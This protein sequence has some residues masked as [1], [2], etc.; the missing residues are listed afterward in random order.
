MHEWFVINWPFIEW[1]P[2]SLVLILGGLLVSFLRGVVQKLML[3]AAPTL[4]LVA[5]L[6]SAPGAYAS[7]EFLNMQMTLGR[8]DP[9]S[10]VFAHV[11]AIMALVGAIYALHVR[12]TIQHVAALIYAGSAMGVVFAGDLV[13]LYVFWELMMLSSVWL[14][15]RNRRAASLAAGFR[16]LLVHAVSGVLLLAGIVIYYTQTG[17]LSFDAIETGS[18]AFWLILLGFMINAAVPPLH[19]WL[20]DAYPEATVTGAVFLCAFTTKTAVYTL[21]RGFPEAEV[22]V[23]LGTLMTLWGVTYAVLANN[24]RR[25]LAY[26]I[27]SQ[28]GFMVAGIGLGTAM[29]LNGSAAHAFT[30]ILYKALLF[31]SAGAIIQMTGRAKLT[32]LGGLYRHMPLTFVFYMIAA[33]S[34]SALPLTS[35][36]V[37]KTM[38]LEAYADHQAA[39]VWLVL[40]LASAGTFL[41]VGLKLPWFVFMGRDSGLRPREAP[42]N[43]LVAMGIVAFF[44]IFIGVYPQWLYQMLPHQPVGYNAYTLAH[45]FWDL[46][47][48]SFVGLV[49]FV[50][51]KFMAPKDKI[52]LDTD[53]FYRVAAPH[54]VGLIHR[55]GTSAWRNLLAAMR[56]PLGRIFA[57]ALRYHGPKG[58]LART[59]PTGSMVLWVAVLLTATLLLYYI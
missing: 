30:H 10:L 48:L 27:V 38:I 31:M 6:G 58:I 29:A 23:W 4:A 9:L 55:H 18:P 13:T 52:T 16:Y 33:F 50:L 25:L 56:W 57:Q 7:F 43:M 2:P 1:L 11:F 22:L 35:G 47:L 36:F 20:T 44:C 46:Q 21:I 17:S 3:L 12:D 51:L 54:A 15:W 14:I 34:I 45:V 24:I 26:H 39:F 8:V 42:A 59:S 5:V 49:F 41:S 28:V 53:W 19:A 40:S 32:E 37:S